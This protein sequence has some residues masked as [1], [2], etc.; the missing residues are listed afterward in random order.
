[1]S[2]PVKL[3]IVEGENRDY[4]FIR[5]MTQCFLKGRYIATVICLPA[6]QNIYMLYNKLAA[7]NFE[8]DIVEVLRE[9]VKTAHDNLM[10]ISRQDIDEVYLFFDYDVHQNNTLSRGP[11]SSKILQAMI[12]VFDNETEH[13]KLYISYPMVEALYDYIEESCYAFS[14]CYISMNEIGDYKTKAGDNNPKASRSMQIQFWREALNVFF[15]R[16]KCLLDLDNLDFSTYRET[17]SPRTI[18]SIE[19]QLMNMCNQVFVLSAFPEFLFDYF[20]EQFWN[21]MTP[22]KRKHFS[23]CPKNQSMIEPLLSEY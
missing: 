6:A 11:D 12:E 22:T 19:N 15:L 23:N 1:M 9:S 10:G 4:R 16:V 3:F 7:D 2:N 20:G 5:E 13:G 18:Y 14:N 21:T 17:V 8:T